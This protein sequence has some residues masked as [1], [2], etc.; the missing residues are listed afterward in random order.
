MS[1][2]RIDD[3]DPTVSY[4]GTWLKG[5]SPNVE[6]EGT[7]SSSTTVGDHF[8]VPFRGT[9]NLLASFI[10]QRVLVGTNIAIFVTFDTTSGGAEVTLSIDNNSTVKVVSQAGLDNIHQQ[11]L[12]RSNL[13]EMGNHTLLVNMTKVN[14]QS[15]VGPNEGTVWFDYFMVADPTRPS[16][17]PVPAGASTSTSSPLLSSTQ[18]S[19]GKSSSESTGPIIGGV[20]GGLF[21]LLGIGF[22]FL[23]FRRKGK[24]RTAE[25]GS[26][27]SPFFAGKVTCRHHPASSK[28]TLV[29]ETRSAIQPFLLTTTDV[30]TGKPVA[31]SGT[32]SN[33]G[34]PPN[35]QKSG[36]I[37]PPGSNSS[38]EPSSSNS[39]SVPLVSYDVRVPSPQSSV[40]NHSAHYVLTD[41]A[42]RRRLL[43]IDR[44]ATFQA[45]SPAPSNENL[46]RLPLQHVDSGIR[47]AAVGG[48][49][50]LVELPPVYSRS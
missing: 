13:L 30:S 16:S 21:L 28:L 49:D 33:P 31:N 11:Q 44:A 47:A 12:W 27:G 2:Y 32:Q 40:D 8:T 9:H 15:E 37:T 42:E 5:G 6:Y 25:N 22:L 29:T 41:R 18:P 24:A 23:F 38:N 35:F 7:V 10:T 4:N 17:T 26:A 39:S 20:F 34:S 3:R 45:N 19:S 1:T 43:Q 48:T 14:P 46:E 36:L 50:A